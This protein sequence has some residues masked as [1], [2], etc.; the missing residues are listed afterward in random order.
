MDNLYDLNSWSKHY[1]E[2]AL[3]EAR[4]RH[5]GRGGTNRR[6]SVSRLLA[7]LALLGAAGLAV[8]GKTRMW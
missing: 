2:E 4:V 5:L 3:Q 8:A 7:K 6:T 1:R